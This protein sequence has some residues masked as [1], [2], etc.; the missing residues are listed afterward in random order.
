MPIEKTSSVRLPSGET[1]DI[2]FVRM[3][4][5]RLMPRRADELI[6]RPTPPTSVPHAENR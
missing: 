4:D 2:V 3:P 1:V 6:K 5:G